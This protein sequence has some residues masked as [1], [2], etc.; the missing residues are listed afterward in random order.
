MNIRAV[1]IPTRK[2]LEDCLAA[3]ENAK[4]GLGFFKRYGCY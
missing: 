3:L 1:P 4:Y 2:A